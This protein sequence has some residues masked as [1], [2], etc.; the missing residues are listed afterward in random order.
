[1]KKEQ[2]RKIIKTVLLTIAAA[3]VVSMAIM[4]PNALQSLDLFYGKK[5]KKYNQKYYIKSKISELKNKNYIEFCHKDNQTFVSLTEK[6]KNLLLKYKLKELTLKKPTKWDN[7][8]RLVIF[9][10]KEYKKHIRDSM[11]KELINFGFLRIQDS[12]WVFP[13]ECEE[14]IIMLKSYFYLGKE[15]LYI[16]AEKIENDSWIK[17]KFD[18]V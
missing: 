1:M 10:I 6:G 12:V 5:R 3:G 14:I 11:R 15:V 8:W 18:L 4:A 7:K 16:I 17:R 9:D 2:R 13:Y